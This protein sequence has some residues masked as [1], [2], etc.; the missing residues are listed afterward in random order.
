MKSAGALYVFR[1]PR[2]CRENH[3]FKVVCHDLAEPGRSPCNMLSFPG[4]EKGS[5]GDLVYKLH[6]NPARFGVKTIHPLTLQLFHVAAH[7]DAIETRFAGWLQDGATIVLDRFWWSTWAYGRFAGA[8]ATTLDAMVEIE[9]RVWGI[10][11]PAT[12]FL[13]S[14]HTSK[15]LASRKRLERLYALLARNEAGFVPV[16]YVQ[17]NGVLKHAQN[18][19][20]SSLL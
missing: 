2:W 19:I 17:N 16:T 3:A 15:S 1:R 14:R 18:Q 8:D 12:I 4:N 11:K 9:K 6:H 5:V 13:V 7:I 10:I 20:L